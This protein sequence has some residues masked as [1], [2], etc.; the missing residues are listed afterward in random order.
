MQELA[1]Y[2]DLMSRIETIVSERHASRVVSIVIGE[3]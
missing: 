2:Q 3:Q 1:I